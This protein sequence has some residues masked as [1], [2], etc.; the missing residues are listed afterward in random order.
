MRALLLAAG[1]GTRLQPLTDVLPKCLAPIRGRPLLEYWLDLLFSANLELVVINA[2]HHVDMVDAYARG[3]PWQERIVV[4]HEPQLLGTGGTILRQEAHFA[5][6]LFL[7]AHADNLT[8]FDCGALLRRHIERPAD[9]MM[10][11]MTFITRSPESSG[12]V[13]LDDRGV[14]REF[15]EKV[16]NPP[17]NLANAAVYVLEPEV[18]GF[19]RSLGK[20]FID[21]S[22]EVIPHYIG[23][24]FTFHNAAYHEDIGSLERWRR[25]Q[26]EFPGAMPAPLPR[27]PWA[28]LLL[29][30]PEV[31]PTVAAL[32]PGDAALR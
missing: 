30:Y 28:A 2:H 10:T 31:M 22:T 32:L 23:R 29:Q 11:M 15:R 3:T 26:L 17:G 1:L 20:P 18:L 9:C 8:S 6:G 24:I 14:V 7:V 21:F 16:A 5:S 27:D 25:A 12:I 13:T 19:L 4:V